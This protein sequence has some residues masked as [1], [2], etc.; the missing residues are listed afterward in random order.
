MLYSDSVL[1]IK[2]RKIYYLEDKTAFT[3]D[4]Q[5]SVQY[6]F[7]YTYKVSQEVGIASPLLEMCAF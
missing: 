3:K 5:K 4:V 6:S 2:G 1:V 7:R